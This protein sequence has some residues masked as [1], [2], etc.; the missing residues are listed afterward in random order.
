MGKVPTPGHKKRNKLILSFDDSARKLVFYLREYLTGFRKRRQQRKE[1]AQTEIEKK[2]KN[3]I[4]Q[5]RTKKRKANQDKIN[6][7]LQGIHMPYDNMNTTSEQCEK[8]DFGTH[9]VTIKTDIDFAETGLIMAQSKNDE[10]TPASSKLKEVKKKEKPVKKMH[11]EKPVRKINKYKG[12][13][14]RRKKK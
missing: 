11:K 2:L 10:V 6:D 3:K 9:E 12:G 13:K 14:V 4:R 7:I 1:K 8:V 5:E